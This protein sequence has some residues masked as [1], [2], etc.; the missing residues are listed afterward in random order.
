M[1]G[2]EEIVYTDLL[3]EDVYIK[4]RGVLYVGTKKS[5]QQPRRNFTEGT[6]LV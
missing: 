4:Y 3:E 1:N 6:S 2:N 5:E